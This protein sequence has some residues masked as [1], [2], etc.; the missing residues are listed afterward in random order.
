MKPL[1]LNRDAAT[2]GFKHPAD[3]WYQIEARGEHPNRAAGVIQVIDDEAAQSIV[4]RFNADAQAGTLRH[5]NELLIDH[6]HFS[7]QPD[8]ETR[9]FGW[10]EQL[11]NRDDGIYGRIRWTATGKAAV[12][13]GDYRFF[14]T[15]YDPKDLKVLNSGAA[16][17]IRPLRLDGLTLTNMFNN[18]GQKPIT[19]RTVGASRCDDR[20][21][22]RAAPPTTNLADVKGRTSAASAAS[23][24]NQNQRTNTMKSIAQKLGLAAEASEDAILAEVTKIQNRATQLEAD[25]TPLKNRMTALETENTTL[26]DEQIASDLATHKVTDEKIVNRLTPVLKTMKNRADRVSFITECVGKPAVPAAQPQTKLF[27]RDTKAPASGKTD[28]KNEKAESVAATKIMNRAHDIMKQTPNMSLPT[29]VR[30]AQTELENA[31]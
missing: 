15:E 19:N 24:Q 14:S 25:A 23:N 18:R 4:N 11:Q 21:A 8:Q 29:A 22:Q 2:G 13:G 1:I 17:R 26:L 28:E 5:G 6:E 7:A 20:T 16:K 12:D 9:A 3:G 27:N 30:M 31:S 10:L